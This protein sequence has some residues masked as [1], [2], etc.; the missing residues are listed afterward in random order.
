MLKRKYSK[1]SSTQAGNNAL[2]LACSRG[3]LE[4]ME[5]ILKD[6]DNE[7][8]IKAITCTNKVSLQEEER[9]AHFVAAVVL[10]P[11]TQAS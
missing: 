3:D 4:A 6:L 10:S 11:F 5:N 2:M 9:A 1:N 7:A 8:A